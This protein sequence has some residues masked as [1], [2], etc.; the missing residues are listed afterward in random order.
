MRIHPSA[1]FFWVTAV[2]VGSWRPPSAA[3]AQSGVQRSPEDGYSSRQL[4]ARR[5]WQVGST[6]ATESCPD[7]PWKVNTSDLTVTAGYAALL[8]DCAGAVSGT[9]RVW[10]TVKVLVN[11][12]F[13]IA[14]GE[15][16]RSSGRQVERLRNDVRFAGRGAS[17][18]QYGFLHR[19]RRIPGRGCDRNQ[20]CLQRQQSV[21]SVS[22]LLCLPSSW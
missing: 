20:P 16:V 11:S 9:E 4:V 18:H 1:V 12:T 19:C 10:P 7:E 21:R 2:A 6:L 8:H 15:E 17:E 5:A 13:R 3:G 22:A 14:P